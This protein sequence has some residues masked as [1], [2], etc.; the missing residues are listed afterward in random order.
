M[1]FQPLEVET[2][3]MRSWAQKLAKQAISEQ[4]ITW[5][6]IYKKVAMSPVFFT[7]HAWAVDNGP[8]EGDIGDCTRVQDTYLILNLYTKE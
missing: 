7:C 6:A 4:G 5:R 3:E 8:L 2:Q 1:N